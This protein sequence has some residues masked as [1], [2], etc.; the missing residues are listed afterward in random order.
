[1]SCL[2]ISDIYEYIDGALSPERREEMDRHLDICPKCRQALEDRQRIAAAASS[3]A[4]FEAP[5]DFADRVMAR[6]AP[7]KVKSPAW[8]IIL[9]ATSTMLA[10]TMMALVASG[11][12]AVEIL[13]RVSH[14]FWAYAKSAA[15]FTAKAAI[16]L[17]LAAKAA[18]PLVESVYGCLSALTSFINPWVQVLILMLTIGVVVSLFFG[19]KKRFSWGG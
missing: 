13:S 7:A 16:L 12:S 11:T 2:R 1:M 10:V 19:I 9:A 17:S 15:V 5:D 4:P 6:V 8:L 14:S 18:R 3:L